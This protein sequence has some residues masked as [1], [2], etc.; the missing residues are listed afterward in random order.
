MSILESL[1]TFFGGCPYIDDLAIIDAET[2]N[3]DAGSYAIA[4][5][6][7]TLVTEYMDG[8]R[9]IQYS[10]A[11][12]FREFTAA[13]AEKLANSGFIDNLAQWLVHCSR[14]GN[15]PVLPTG[16]ECESISSANGMLYSLDE[17]GNA[18][19]YHIQCQMIYERND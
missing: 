3:E 16:M 12:Q 13:N 19:N 14:S 6:G 10:F 7:E 8:A 9:L 15:L 1:I 17:S 4:P 11:F 2:T 5:T 18:G